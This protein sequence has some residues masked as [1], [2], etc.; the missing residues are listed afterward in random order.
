M[1][2]LEDRLRIA[3]G[4]GMGVQLT[5]GDVETV[6]R[7]LVA[8]RKIRESAPSPGLHGLAKEALRPF[9]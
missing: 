9:E 2:K 7:M 8:L 3:L 6:C 4:A 5:S 1:L